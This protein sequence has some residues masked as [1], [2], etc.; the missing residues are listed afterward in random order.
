MTLT[1]KQKLVILWIMF[2]L[3]V[4]LL[5]F[6]LLEMSNDTSVVEQKKYTVT[7]LFEHDGCKVYQFFDQQQPR[8]FAKCE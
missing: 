7:M 2:G 6:L 5:P 4:I 3:I 8:Y 1:E